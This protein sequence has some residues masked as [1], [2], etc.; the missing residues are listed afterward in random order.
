VESDDD[1]LPHDE[2]SGVTTSSDTART[3]EI[4]IDFIDLYF[5]ATETVVLMAGYPPLFVT[6]RVTLHVAFLEGATNLPETI[7][8]KPDSLHVFL[9]FDAAT[10]IFDNVVLDC[11]FTDVAITVKPGRAFNTAT[12]TA[13][14]V[15]E[16]ATEMEYD[17]PFFKPAMTHE[18][19][20]VEHDAPPGC[21]VATYVM[22]GPSITGGTH[23][24][25]NA[26]FFATA[27]ISTKGPGRASGVV[28]DAVIGVPAPT[29]LIAEID[30]V[31]KVLLTRFEI[32]HVNVTAS[33]LHAAPPGI[34]V[35]E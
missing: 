4:F 28:A 24:N 16:A 29:E 26:L 6:V 27:E 1:E 31:Y 3:R 20:A 22:P 32:V 12:D 5:T 33:T 2:R 11:F 7:E 9:P 30:A 15:F 25:D 34:N 17:T 8:H 21:A 10:T 18:V 14:L 13:P 23:D 19:D 35:A